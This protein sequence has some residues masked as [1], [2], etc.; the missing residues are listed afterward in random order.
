MAY[1]YKH[2]A[3]EFNYKDWKFLLNIIRNNIFSLSEDEYFCYCLL[4]Y[5]SHLMRNY[6]ISTI[7]L[8]F[9]DKWMG[10]FKEILDQLFRNVREFF[11]AALKIIYIF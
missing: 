3:V 7:F 4:L 10:N 8:K 6:D 2:N 1:D 5:Y 9:L 11:K